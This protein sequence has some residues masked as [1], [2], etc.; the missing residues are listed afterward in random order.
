[1]DVRTLHWVLGWF[2]GVDLGGVARR[3][4]M[5]LLLA[6][7][8]WRRV[9]GSPKAVGDGCGHRLVGGL[10]RRRWMGFSQ[11]R[12]RNPKG[13]SVTVINGGGCYLDFRVLI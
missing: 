7:S 10:T 4:V 5:A 8:G 9:V 12:E 13:V 6:D 2:G 11:E 3:G 1:M